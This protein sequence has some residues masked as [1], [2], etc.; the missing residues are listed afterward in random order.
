MWHEAAHRTAV[1]QDFDSIRACGNRA[2]SAGAQSGRPGPP[3]AGERA[4][5]VRPRRSAMRR[6]QSFLVRPGH[7]ISDVAFIEDVVRIHGIVTGLLAA[8]L[9]EG[10]HG[11]GLGTVFAASDPSHISG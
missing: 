7:S 6:R 9:D 10:S 8:T 1:T 11:V 2:I 5:H 3:I 4:V